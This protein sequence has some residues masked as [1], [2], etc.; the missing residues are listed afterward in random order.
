[1]N[2]RW[3]LDALPEVA[4][5]RPLLVASERWD[6]LT[7]PIE[8][9][10]HW[11]E[12]PSERI[13]EAATQAGGGVVALGGGSA[14]DLGKAISAAASV[15]LVSIPTTYSGA[16]WTDFYGVRDL[17]NGGWSAAAAARTRSASSTR[18]T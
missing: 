17:R 12:V 5:E 14:I 6:S 4:P 11:R 2:V 15:P 7:L 13:G 16:E 1:M 9:A 10:A 8:P 3:G 18:S